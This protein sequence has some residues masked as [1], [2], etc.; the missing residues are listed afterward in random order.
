MYFK[1]ELPY[2]L[3][4]IPTP[5]IKMYCNHCTSNQ[6]F[7][8]DGYYF[9][10]GSLIRNYNSFGAIIGFVYLCRGCG[11]FKRYFFIEIGDDS[12]WV[13]KVGQFP[14][15]D[16]SM[17]KQ[18]RSLLNKNQIDIYQ[19]GLINESQS[20]GIGAFAYYR[21]IVEDIID[22]LLNEISVMIDEKNKE[23]YD[24]ALKA[25]RESHSGEDKI[26]A[27]YDL[28][29]PRLTPNGNNPLKIFRVLD[30]FLFLKL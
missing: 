15:W 6:T 4:D 17:D 18:I 26:K 28:L 30:F 7:N 16:I 22:E 29:P 12:K 27:V 5:A 3:V 23:E 20:Y 9:K 13:Q 21:R 8:P 25:I 10:Q 11:S 2:N 19:K 14:P 1:S 24:N